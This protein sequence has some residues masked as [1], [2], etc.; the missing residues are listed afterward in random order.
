MQLEHTLEACNWN[1]HR[2]VSSQSV[3]WATIAGGSFNIMSKTEHRAT[4]QF[5]QTSIAEHLPS[6]VGRNKLERWSARI[7]NSMHPKG[8][9]L[10]HTHGQAS[11]LATSTMNSAA[12]LMTSLA[13][14]A[15]SQQHA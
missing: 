12:T 5:H 13:C 6:L 8:M 15:S 14:W 4:A 1:T 10:G 2:L 9:L 11:T 3:L 7:V